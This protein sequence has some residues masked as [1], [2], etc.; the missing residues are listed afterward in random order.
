MK[1]YLV[2]GIILSLV[3]SVSCEKGPS[4][5]PVT[6]VS[7]NKNSLTLTE[8]ETASLSA[9]VLPTDATNRNVSWSSNDN[10]IASVQGGVVTA[11][12][13]GSAIITVKT[14]D[15]GKTA[16]CSIIVEAKYIAVSG[17]T[18]DKAS[19]SMYDDEEITLIATI[20]PANATEKTI[21]WESSDESVAT[22]KDGKV[23]AHKEGSVDIIASVGN[24]SAKCVVT[25]NKRII[26]VEGISLSAKQKR[27]KIGETFSIECSVSPSNANNFELT[28]SSNNE[29]IASVSQE[30]VITANKSGKASITVM[31]EDKSETVV[32][33]VFNT[34][35][36]YYSYLVYD[37]SKYTS[38]AYKN[39]DMIFEATRLVIQDMFVNDSQKPFF[40]AF[41]DKNPMRA[42]VIEDGNRYYLNDI[43]NTKSNHIQCSWYDKNTLYHVVNYP[44]PIVNGG[45]AIWVGYNKKYDISESGELSPYAYIGIDDITVIG[46][47]VY[48]CG[49]IAEPVDANTNKRYPVLWKNGKIYIKYETEKDAS[50]YQ[51]VNADGK[52]YLLMQSTEQ[53]ERVDYIS[54]WD[55]NGKCYDVG[56]SY[57]AS[58]GKL[59]WFGSKLYTTLNYEGTLSI[60]EGKERLFEIKDVEIDKYA[61]DYIDGDIYSLIVK[62]EKVGG[63]FYSS[64]FLYRNDKEEKV[65]VK[66]QV[67]PIYSGGIRVFAKD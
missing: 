58:A 12:K 51:V 14:E 26:H 19:L 28:Y 27:L 46:N 9:S 31:A 66:P 37:Y 50:F 55:E 24:M 33:S 53:S 11:I 45:Y 13:Q 47:D 18:L 7:L 67:N 8:G 23:T 16:S 44:L 65:I 25:V 41:E 64:A 4:S 42:T 57:Y 32:I 56:K 59:Y 1:K 35:D 54:V 60:Y 3:G 34:D 49:W 20:S 62:S 15:G 38:W 63:T 52:L 5:V 22:V 48:T 61:L 40:V 36:I 17:V 2:L 39:E 30:G 43:D 21:K 10:T 29:S 6:S